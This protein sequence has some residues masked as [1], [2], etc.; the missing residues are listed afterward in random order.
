M[1]IPD[2][3]SL[4]SKFVQAV[5]GSAALLVAIVSIVIAVLTY[6]RRGK[7][8]FGKLILDFDKVDATVMKERGEIPARD[9]AIDRPGDKQFALLSEYHSQGLA[10]SRISFWLSLIFAGLGFAVI[11]SALLIMDN[12]VKLADQ[13]KPFVSVVSGIYSVHE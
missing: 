7:V 13:A 4:F 10:Q 6:L 2:S 5:S 3:G 12:N 9:L 1:S 8:R 11:V